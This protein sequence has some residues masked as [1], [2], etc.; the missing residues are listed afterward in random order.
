MAN[1]GKFDLTGKRKEDTTETR[2]LKKMYDQLGDMYG[3][4][5]IVPHEL[6][7]IVNKLR[8]EFLKDRG[9]LSKECALELM[10]VEKEFDKLTERVREYHKKIRD[11]GADH[12][13]REHNLALKF[14]ELELKVVRQHLQANKV[15]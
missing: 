10:P 5:G 2:L 9:K 1:L 15:K 14:V 11:M 12:K 3:N 13:K 6:Q 8:D 7:L 4:M